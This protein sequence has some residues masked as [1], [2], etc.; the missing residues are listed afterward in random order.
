MFNKWSNTPAVIFGPG[1]IELAHRA[2]EYIEINEL[3][4]FI[5]ILTIMLLSWCGFE[6]DD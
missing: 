2:N 4:E 5:K 1:N 6:K 3:K